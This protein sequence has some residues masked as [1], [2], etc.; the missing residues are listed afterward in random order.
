MTLDAIGLPKSTWH[1]WKNKKV[2]Y[3]AKY[4]SL[5]EPLLEVLTE[6]PTYGYRRVEPELKA[7]GYLVAGMDA[8][9]LLQVLYTDYTE[10]C[11]HEVGRR[12][13]SCPCWITR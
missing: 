12:R 11:M 8:A 13:P 1:Y 3:E 2:D 5:M 9:K 6:N 4:K 7:R 10:I